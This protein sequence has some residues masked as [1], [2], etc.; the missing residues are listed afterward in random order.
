M[1]P[2]RRLLTPRRLAATVEEHHFLPSRL[3]SAHARYYTRE[4]RVKAY[5]QLL[6]SYRSVTLESLCSAFG[7]SKE[8]LDK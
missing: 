2:L 4:L 3:L 5:A 6:E 1:H 8:W 7:V